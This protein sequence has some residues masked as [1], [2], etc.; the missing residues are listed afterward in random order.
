MSIELFIA[1]ILK[2]FFLI[3]SPVTLLVGI[4]LMFDI[5]TYMRLEKFLVRV[6]GLPKKK[7]IK[8]IGKEREALQMFLLKKRRV[9]GFIC[10][11][12][13]V[14]AF[15]FTYTFLMKRF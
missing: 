14:V 2:I 8:Q 7:I 4:F 13:S 12:H 3:T 6:Y 15:I 9:I 1:N 5:D 10:L 11:L